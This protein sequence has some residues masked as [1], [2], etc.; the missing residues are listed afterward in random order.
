MEETEMKNLARP[1]RPLERTATPEELV[2]HHRRYLAAK[3]SLFATSHESIAALRSGL[4]RTT[5]APAVT[6]GELVFGND[7]HLVRP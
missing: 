6:M 4:K 7:N 2:D 5:N 3:P 1:K